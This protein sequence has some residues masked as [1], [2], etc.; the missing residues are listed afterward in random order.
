MVQRRWAGESVGIVDTQRGD[1]GG[2]Q[3]E[4]S[5]V[6]DRQWE[7]GGGEQENQ[8]EYYADNEGKVN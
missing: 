3:E 4:S 1:G 7:D 2:E 5:G 8:L 6:L